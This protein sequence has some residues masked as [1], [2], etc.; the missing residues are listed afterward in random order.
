MENQLTR[1]GYNHWASTYDTQKNRTRDL[2]AKAIRQILSPGF[3]PHILELGCG[4]GKNSAW[5]AS[6]CDRLISV[7]FSEEMLAR[8]RQKNLGPGVRFIQ[9]DILGKWDFGNHPFDLIVFSLVL[10]HIENLEDIFEKASLC[11]KPNGYIYLGEL[12]PY[13]QYLGSKARFETANG[14]TELPCFIHDIAEYFAAALK[15]GFTLVNLREWRDDDDPAMPPRIISMLFRKT[16]PTAEWYNQTEGKDKLYV[17][18]DPV[19]RTV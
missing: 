4:T 14:V 2:E 3:F 12:H 18:R 11:L 10:E 17:D 8:A 19:I 16:D 5:L 15:F 7:D 13:K 9:A 6:V 1:Q